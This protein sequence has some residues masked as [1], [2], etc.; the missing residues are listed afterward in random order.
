MNQIHPAGFIDG[1]NAM[2]ALPPSRREYGLPGRGLGETPDLELARYRD[3][4]PVFR[5]V[6]F[7]L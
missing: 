3:L 6:E 7:A 5:R 4:N 1:W 2:S